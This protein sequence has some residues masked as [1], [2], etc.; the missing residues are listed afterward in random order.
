MKIKKF[1]IIMAVVLIIQSPL[2]S[3]DTVSY[4]AEIDNNK[5]TVKYH[6]YNTLSKFIQINVLNGNYDVDMRNWLSMYRQKDI[7]D[8]TYNTKMKL[9]TIQE[10]MIDLK[11]MMNCMLNSS[12]DEEYHIYLNGYNDTLTYIYDIIDSIEGI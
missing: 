11:D 5:D 2:I 7:N 10:C 3:V 6:S 4:A 12:S 1:A 8:I 9:E